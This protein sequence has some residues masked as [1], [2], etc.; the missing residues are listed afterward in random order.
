MT[1]IV[2]R[3]FARLF[4]KKIGEDQF[5][6]EYLLSRCDNAY[7]KKK[8]MVL[9]KGLAEPTKVPA[10]WHSWLHYTSD[11]IP[12]NHLAYSWQKNHLPNRSGTSL[13][14]TP[15][16]TEERVEPSRGLYKAWHPKS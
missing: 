10:N 12:K 13:A 14:Y 2:N 16:D 5:G 8:R 9:Y 6:N 4:Y 1:D 3:L 7:G 15:P 11:D